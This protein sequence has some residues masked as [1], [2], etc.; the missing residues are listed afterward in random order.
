MIES[1]FIVMIA[2]AFLLFVLG[3]EKGVEG[4]MYAGVSLML[5]IML[6]AQSFYIEVPLD[7]AYNEAGFRAFCLIFI[8]VNLVRVI[9]GVFPNIG[10]KFKRG[11]WG[12]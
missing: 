5:W 10:D 6:M 11:D 9:F 2:I 3:I 8:F 7:A 4:I 1:L 12:G